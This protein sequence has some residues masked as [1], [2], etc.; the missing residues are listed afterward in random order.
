MRWCYALISQHTSPRPLA[1]RGGVRAVAGHRSL[2]TGWFSGGA[3]TQCYHGSLD[4]SLRAPGDGIEE[5][6]V[7]V[8]GKQDRPKAA[9][10]APPLRGLPCPCSPPRGRAAT[11][12]GL[13]FPGLSGLT[14]S[15][16]DPK[17]PEFK[18]GKKKNQTEKT[19][20]KNPQTLLKIG[21]LSSSL[22]CEMATSLLHRKEPLFCCLQTLCGG[23]KAEAS[24]LQESVFFFKKKE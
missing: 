5:S 1:A 23:K 8:H 21:C 15:N 7:H 10:R 4:P 22:S 11:P 18:N 17:T 9:G 2:V 20:K 3:R 19:E 24:S 13:G 12:V 16:R 14:G 6:T